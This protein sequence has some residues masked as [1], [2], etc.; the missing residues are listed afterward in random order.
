MTIDKSAGPVS[1]DKVSRPEL[2]IK[3][4]V[5]SLEQ[6]CVSLLTPHTSEKEGPAETRALA[7]KRIE[8]SGYSRTKVSMSDS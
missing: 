6:L 7:E 8:N 4:R 5:L 2:L 3:T 1:P